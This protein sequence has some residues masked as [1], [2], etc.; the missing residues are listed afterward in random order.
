M[1]KIFLQSPEWENIQKKLGRKTRR[2]QDCLV[3][4]HCVP[5]G[6]KYL[7]AP[8]PDIENEEDFFSSAE[9]IAKKEG[10]I[11][12]KVD[13]VLPVS[14]PKKISSHALQPQKTIICN[15]EKSEAELLSAMHEKTRYNIRLAERK[16]IRIADS[17]WQRVGSEDREKKLDIFWTMLRNTAERDG[18]HT[19]EKSYYEKLLGGYSEYFSNELFFAEH[20]GQPI[21]AAL[22][23]FYKKTAT[24][25]HGA[26]SLEHRNLM[27]PHLLHWRIM[28]EAKKRGFAEYDFW[29][30]N[31]NRWPGVTRFKRG[32]GGKE[33]VYPE[34]FD[35]IYR[36]S[37]YTL[38]S[39]V[40][41]YKKRAV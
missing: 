28:Q 26:S 14:Y 1:Q 36:K 23:N 15:L 22:I 9:R 34:S 3:I 5:L 7:Y 37:Y 24:Y 21:A 29:G 30:I 17:G 12:L 35:I 4:E 38:Y 39:L 25:L 41:A 16:G 27:A 19:H 6:F 31:D 32:F 8:R 33:V 2:I 13:P 10:H 20:E 18:F 40:R 11:F